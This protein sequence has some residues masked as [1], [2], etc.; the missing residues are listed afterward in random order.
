MKNKA[1]LCE[2]INRLDSK[3]HT[4]CLFVANTGERIP[5]DDTLKK[6]IRL[7]YEDQLVS[8]QCFEGGM[9]LIGDNGSEIINLP[10]GFNVTTKK[11]CEHGKR[12]C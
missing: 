8:A 6:I 12:I 2:V 10:D 4:I 1:V 5:I 9:C 11:R 7:Y 3:E